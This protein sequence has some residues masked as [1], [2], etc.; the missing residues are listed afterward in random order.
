MRPCDVCR[1]PN[2]TTFEQTLYGAKAI[3]RLCRGHAKSRRA[4]GYHLK[5]ANR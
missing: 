2:A 4:L 1:K 3:V 5:A